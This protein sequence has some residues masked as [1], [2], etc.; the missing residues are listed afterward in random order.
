[1]AAEINQEQI[2]L[3]KFKNLSYQQKQSV[4]DFMHFLLSQNQSITSNNVSSEKQVSF[5]EAT[6]EVAGSLDWGPGDLATNKIYLEQM[7]K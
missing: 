1:M 3:E 2:M 7:G 6:K 4:L 5:Y